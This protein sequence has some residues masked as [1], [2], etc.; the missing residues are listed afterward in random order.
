MVESRLLE[1]LDDREIVGLAVKY[2]SA[3][4]NKNWQMLHSVFAPD[5][6]LVAGPL[7]EVK[8]PE[9]IGLAIER[10]LDGQVTQHLNGNHVVSVQGDIASHSSYLQAQHVR[11]GMMGVNWYTIA[12]TYEDELIRMREGWRIC[13]RTLTLTWTNG[14]PDAHTIPSF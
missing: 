6:V 5:G 1:M 9:A 10:V 13:R 2:A 8:G 12:G 7:G 11:P 14:N 4:D 3:L